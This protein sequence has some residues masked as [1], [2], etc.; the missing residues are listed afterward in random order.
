MKILPIFVFILLAC[1]DNNNV[2]H[3]AERLTLERE[4]FNSA[5]VTEQD[6]ARL[7]AL[8]EISRS[9][10]H[11]NDIDMI[12]GISSGDSRVFCLIE[13]VIGYDFSN[14]GLGAELQR[15]RFMIE[16]R[17]RARL[18]TL[19]SEAFMPS[20]T[21]QL[22]QTI[23]DEVNSVLASGDVNEILIMRLETFPVPQTGNN[24]PLLRLN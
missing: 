17:V 7:R 4:L 14:H 18:S 23:A 11:F 1:S 16:D 12:R 24:A 20:R 3:T 5:T 19:S 13:F 8:P 22:R 9:H 21:E 2:N 6:L 15:G 10:I